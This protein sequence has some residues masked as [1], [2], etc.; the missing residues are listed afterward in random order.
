MLHPEIACNKYRTFWSP[1]LLV[2]GAIVKIICFYCLY[3]PSV[4]TVALEV[5]NTRMHGLIS[6]WINSYKLVSTLMSRVYNDQGALNMYVL[7][8]LQKRLNLTP[9]VLL[10]CMYMHLLALL[11]RW[12]WPGSCSLVMSV[13]K[14]VSARTGDLTAASRESQRADCCLHGHR[15]A[16]DMHELYNI[17]LS[18]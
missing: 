11:L 18:T 17:L 6:L 3:F 9:A 14:S 8:Y 15:M 2:S 1:S 10:I 12:E 4:L 13:V 5:E 7:F 16:A